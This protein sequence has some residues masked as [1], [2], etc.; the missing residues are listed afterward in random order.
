MFALAPGY[1]RVG[2]SVRLSLDTS[3]PSTSPL[4]LPYPI[5]SC[6]Q[7]C[8]CPEEGWQGC[9]R[10]CPKLQKDLRDRDRVNKTRRQLFQDWTRRFSFEVGLAMLPVLVDVRRS[11]YKLL[12]G[13]HRTSSCTRFAVQAVVPHSPYNPSNGIRCTTRRL[14]M[15]LGGGKYCTLCIRGTTVGIEGRGMLSIIL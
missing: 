12:Y 11:P 5:V 1:S 6:L 14:W 7:F 10:Y 15:L 8:D 4:T 3:L 9:R 2:V 13:M